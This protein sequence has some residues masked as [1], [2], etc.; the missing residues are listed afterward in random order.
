MKRVAIFGCLLVLGCD[1]T[2]AKVTGPTTVAA[3]ETATGSPDEIDTR[4]IVVA[5]PLGFSAAS[6]Q[7]AEIVAAGPGEWVC[8]QKVLADE[9][10]L[11]ASSS[12]DCFHRP[13]DL[14]WSLYAVDRAAK[15]LTFNGFVGYSDELDTIAVKGGVPEHSEN[16]SL[17]TPEGV[18]MRT[19]S[20][21]HLTTFVNLKDGSTQQVEGDLGDDTY[22]FVEGRKQ[23]V[24]TGYEPPMGFQRDYRIAV[25]DGIPKT[26][27]T[28]KTPTKYAP[29]DATVSWNAERQLF[30]FR[31]RDCRRA[32]LAADGSKVTCEVKLPSEYSSGWL[33]G[34][35]FVGAPGHG[36]PLAINLVTGDQI[37]PAEG[38]CSRPVLPYI[39]IEHDSPRLLMGCPPEDRPNS[40]VKR[41]LLWTPDKTLEVP[42]APWN[43]GTSHGNFVELYKFGI[44]P[45]SRG[46]TAWLD[47]ERFVLWDVDGFNLEGRWTV[48]DAPPFKRAPVKKFYALDADAPQLLPLG[49]VK[50][51]Q[52]VRVV[53]EDPDVVSV[54]C[55][56]VKVDGHGCGDDGTNPP[57]EHTVTWDR[58]TGKRWDGA[59]PLVGVTKS[60]LVFSDARFLG[61]QDKPCD[62]KKL[63]SAPR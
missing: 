31:A 26:R 62:A 23:L 58:K 13:R 6:A 60:A 1:R 34:D 36:A 57:I 21:S 24:V 28:L 4:D 55:T 10:R 33:K 59:R 17:Q 9:D 54:A 20:T 63:F 39:A 37:H 35:W 32:T 19:V 25:L 48:S 14:Q 11:V 45:L 52:G 44:V 15:L 61:S 29:A 27:P 40:K 3:T 16:V 12:P 46:D 2:P 47:V 42:G 49:D 18:T 7:P 43:Q 30:E 50:C 53:Y 51:E 41:L 38:L 5:E 8:L 22:H 56:G